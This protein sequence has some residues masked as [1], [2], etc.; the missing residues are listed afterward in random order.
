MHGAEAVP[1][2]WKQA[3]E[4]II[5]NLP[6]DMNVDASNAS[7]VLHSVT[8]EAELRMNES[9]GRQWKVRKR[10]GTEVSLRDMYGVIVACV[11]KFQIV[12]DIAVQADAGYASIPWAMVRLFLTAAISEHETYGMML[13]GMEIVSGLVTHYIVIERVYMGEISVSAQQVRKSLLALYTAILEYLI[14]AVRYFGSNRYMQ[15]LKGF[16]ITAPNKIKRLLGAVNNAKGQVDANTAHANA[17][18]ELRGL[19]RLQEGQNRLWS[20][21]QHNGFEEQE[22]I[23]RLQEIVAEWQTPLVSIGDKVADLHD[24]YEEKQTQKILD[25]VSPVALEPYHATVQGS[26]LESTGTWLLQDQDYGKWEDSSRSSILW[27]RGFLG[28]GK[29]RLISLVIDHVRERVKSLSLH[30]NLAFFYCVRSESEGDRRTVDPFKSD[31]VEV[32]RSIVKQLSVAQDHTGAGPVIRQKYEQLR[33][34][35]DEPRRLKLSECVELIIAMAV[36]NPLIIIIDAL[37]EL[38]SGSRLD[39]I[40]GLAEIVNKSRSSVKVF[41]STR[42]IDSIEKL[43]VVYPVIDVNETRNGEDISRFISHEL[44]QKIGSGLRER[45]RDKIQEKLYE[46][47]RGMFWY[48]SLQ[49]NLLF[50]SER[51][52][53]ER[54]MLEELDR[55]PSSITGLYDKIVDEIERETLD[56]NRLA[57]QNSLKWLLCCQEELSTPVFLEAVSTVV[58]GELFTPEPSLIHSACRTLVI[59]TRDE[60]K[61]FAFAHLSV[62]EYLAKRP[63]Y[64]LSE[65]HLVA[66]ESCLRM[67]ASILESSAMNHVL[68]EPQK[69]FARYASL[70]WPIH[71]QNIDFSVTSDRKENIKDLLKAFMLRGPRIAPGFR[72]WVAQI[73]STAKELGPRNPALANKLRSLKASLETPLLTACVFGFPDVIERLSKVKGFD[74]NQSNDDGQTALCL[75]VENGQLETIETLLA[76]GRVE[77]NEFNVRALDSDQLEGKADVICYASALQAAAV[78]G[79]EKVFQ[80]LVKQGANIH[81]VAGY[82]G[83]V[84]QGA[85]LKGNRE[86]VSILVEEEG[87]DVNSQGGFHGNAL[88]AASLRGDRSITQK[89]IDAGACVTAPGGHYGSPLMAATCSGNREIILD[90]LERADINVKSGIYGTPLQKAADMDREDLLRLMI[91]NGADINAHNSPE[92]PPMA[93]SNAGSALAAAAWGGHNKIVSLLL[94]NRA[95]ADLSHT[96]NAFHIFHQAAIRGMVDLATYCLQRGCDANMTTDKGPKYHSK[97]GKMTPLAFACVE[98]HL[99]IATLLLQTGASVDYSGDQVTALQFAALRGNARIVDSLVKAMIHRK[100]KRAFDEYVRRIIT[101]NVETLMDFAVSGSPEATSTLL[102][103]GA[104][105]SGNKRGITPLHRAAATNKIEATKAILDHFKQN[106]E[107]LDSVLNARN[108]LGKTA[109]VDAAERGLSEVF[110]LL[111]QSGADWRISDNNKSSVLHYVTWRNHKDVLRQALQALDSE[112]LQFKQSFLASRNKDQNTAMSEALSRNNFDCVRLLLDH[113]DILA[114]QS[115]PTRRWF[116]RIDDSTNLHDVELAIDAF[117]S[118]PEQLASFLNYRNGARGVTMLHE[119]ARHNRVDI[120]E[121]VLAEGADITT[122]HP[123]SFKDF[124]PKTVLHVAAHHGQ[125]AIF[126]LFLDHARQRCNDQ[127]FERFVNKGNE[128]RKT[129]L[130]DAAETNRPDIMK[131]LL[132]SGADYSATDKDLFNALHYCAFRKHEHCVELLLQAASHENS[133]DGTK[134]PVFLNQPSRRWRIT[135]LLDVAWAGLHQIARMLLNT[136]HVNYECYNKDAMSVLHQTCNRPEAREGEQAETLKVF[137]AYMSNDPDQAKFKRVLEK[138]SVRGETAVDVAAGNNFLDMVGILESYGATRAQAS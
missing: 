127:E 91:E 101:D 47:S 80:F 44:R 32:F 20:Q 50:S 74:F 128:H 62:Q 100:G 115:V 55:L 6:K 120:A 84:L 52:M 69:A 36:N 49:M 31:P 133:S 89:L 26:R 70:Y 121:L 77:V 5:A 23:R 90:L 9:Q 78:N 102:A 11:R 1:N 103:H 92:N 114:P 13:E 8:D 126:E 118:H 25:W 108:Y 132:D 19:D 59:Q 56:R 16:D 138:R 60:S 109:L 10:N 135:P 105:L 106:N 33:S 72:N 76:R 88:Q 131:L 81:L 130:I 61:Y 87:A 46:L 37:D 86:I 75:A 35:V 137:L 68:S 71:Y 7:S 17:E 12:G 64:T 104:S 136:H 34:D 116:S 53:D 48:A 113:A 22:K 65:C 112:D 66:A 27:L 24:Q 45:L 67:M 122:P 39:L 43:L 14:E 73:P 107:G 51:L 134:Y 4:K 38:N 63:E 28:H 18:L 98:D 119:A 93:T 3:V 58:R 94:R 110:A 79:S 124:D 111:L 83:S 82:Y 21:L 54:T 95:E 125:K 97:Q 57:A 30:G 117:R 41:L 99:E 123:V 2:V 85:C 129:A 42:P 29:T 40:K 96:E 15:K